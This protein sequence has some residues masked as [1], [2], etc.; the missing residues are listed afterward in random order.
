MI[1]DPIKKRKDELPDIHFL[2]VGGIRFQRGGCYLKIQLQRKEVVSKRR[3]GMKSALQARR[4][5]RFP[6]TLSMELF[7][8]LSAAPGFNSYLHLF[9]CLLCVLNH[10]CV[11]AAALVPI[12]NCC[13]IINLFFCFLS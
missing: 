5:R 8:H 11:H 3:P 10:S 9:Q 7:F 1:S 4:F 2:A 13:I 12:L 6:L